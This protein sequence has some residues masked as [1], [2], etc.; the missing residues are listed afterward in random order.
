M[1]PL[2]G[3]EMESTEERC[4]QERVLTASPTKSS[5]SALEYEFENRVSAFDG[6]SVPAFYLSIEN[7][8]SDS[9]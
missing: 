1:L 3:I 9:L 4:P 2:M 7:V 5:S 8:G 6:R